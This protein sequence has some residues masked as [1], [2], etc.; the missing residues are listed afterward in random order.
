MPD[1]RPTAASD[2]NGW[3][4]VYITAAVTS[5]VMGTSAAWPMWGKA[6]VGTHGL[7]RH[8]PTP[9]AIMAA[10]TIPRSSRV[11]VEK[12]VGPAGSSVLVGYARMASA[13]QARIGPRQEHTE[14]DQQPACGAATAER[15]RGLA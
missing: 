9:T 2:A 4:S 15:E 1:S 12:L 14:D 7:V 13:S 3:L 8:V 5:T 6:A 10:I 11:I